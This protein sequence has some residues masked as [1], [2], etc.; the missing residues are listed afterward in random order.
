MHAG[1]IID[2]RPFEGA[3]G[4]AGVASWMALN[5]VER[6][7]YRR[8]GCLEAEIGAAGIVRRLVWRIKS[9]DESRVLGMAGGDIAAITLQQIFDAA[10][11]GD[12]VSISVVRDTAR[13]IGMAVANLVVITDPNMVILGGLIADA[14]DQ[15]LQPS[16]AEAL[17]ARAP[18]HLGVADGCGCDAGRRRRRARRR[19]CGDARPM[20]VLAG[21][22]IVLPDRILTNA[23]LVIDEG[24]IAAIETT[25]SVP[26]GASIVDVRDGFIVPGFIDVHVHGIEGHDTLDGGDAIASIASRLPRY[27]VTAFCP[28]TVACDPAGLRAV[29]DQ[30]G[31]ARMGRPRGSARVLP[32][33]LE[34]NFINPDYN[35]AQPRACLRLPNDESGEG[36]FTGRDI[37]ATI[38]S[39]RADVGIIT[40]APELP[41]TLELVPVLVRAG[42][43]VSL[44]SFRR[45]FRA[46][47]CGNRRRRA[48][49]NPPFQPNDADDAS[50]TWSRRRGPVTRRSQRGA[51]LRR[52][53]P[54]PGD[55]P[56]RDRGE[57][58]PRCDSHYRWHRRIRID[59]WLDRSSR[60]TD[61]SR[62]RSGGGARRR[63]ARWK[64][65][66][67]GSRIP[68]HRHDVPRVN[69][70]GRDHVFD[71]AG[72][73]GRPHGIWRD[74][75]KDMRRISSCSIAPFGWRGRS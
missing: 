70:G 14:A 30:V 47:G 45:R 68:E 54:A 58:R 57:G 60:R 3:H 74:R 13:Y 49:R 64:H 20:I 43:R 41:G 75:R 73:G 2:G 46:G 48:P 50:G 62:L 51:H 66:D 4:V 36:Q 39:G 25:R 26:S 38:E 67:D 33:H 31:R 40:I 19:P 16:R 18:D 1:L 44:W 59:P 8:F 28:T 9:G 23:A 29:L 61:D 22:D 35:G 32:A 72:A 65:L 42:H 37:L 34:S 63:N 10:R 5:P 6:E 71:D 12:G 24:R 69:C 53:P 52:L 55:M 56:R 11:A 15:L 27:G 17:P 21:G 7:D